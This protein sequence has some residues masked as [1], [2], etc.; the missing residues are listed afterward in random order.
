LFYDPL[1]AVVM[2]TI[3]GAAVIGLGIWGI[4]EFIWW[5]A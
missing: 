3:A 2:A 1:L 5:I 4:V